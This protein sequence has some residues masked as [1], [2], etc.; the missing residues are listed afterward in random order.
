[1][2]STMSLVTIL[3]EAQYQA[4]GGFCCDRFKSWNPIAVFLLGFTNRIRHVSMPVCN[5][6][7]ICWFS[8]AHLF[9]LTIGDLA[10]WCINFYYKVVITSVIFGFFFLGN[11]RQRGRDHATPSQRER[12][13]PWDDAQYCIE[14][15]RH[16]TKG[17]WRWN[18]KS[19]KA[20]GWVTWNC[21]KS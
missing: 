8:S 21:Q 9:L 20:I 14:N 2:F 19:T 12:R 16:K 5:N 10:W 15:T 6:T 3:S 13:F 1:M 7:E 4:R 17:K 18:R 11:M